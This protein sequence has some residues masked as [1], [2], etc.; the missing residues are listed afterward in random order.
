M[1]LVSIFHNPQCSKSNQALALLE[2][3]GIEFTIIN[4]MKNPLR[5]HQIKELALKLGVSV[6]EITRE[7]EPEYRSQH[8][9]EASDTELAEAI[10]KTP[11]LMQRPIVVK[12]DNALVGRPTEI[13]LEILD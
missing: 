4:Y 8:L 9:E 12:G 7:H 11:K 10:E 3:N 13:L 1:A 2:E 5:A 6:R